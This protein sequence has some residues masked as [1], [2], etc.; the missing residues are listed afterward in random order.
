MLGAPF[1]V[2][3]PSMRNLRGGNEDN[4]SIRTACYNVCKIPLGCADIARLLGY[5]PRDTLWDFEWVTFDKSGETSDKSGVQEYQSIMLLTRGLTSGLSLKLHDGFLRYSQRY[6]GTTNILE[7][8]DH[9]PPSSMDLNFPDHSIALQASDTVRRRPEL[10]D[11]FNGKVYCAFLPVKEVHDTVCS[12]GGKTLITP[13]QTKYFNSKSRV[14]R[15]A[16]EEGYLV[17]PFVTIEGINEVEKGLSDIALKAKDLGLDPGRTRYWVKFDNLAGGEGVLPYEPLT[18]SVEEVKSWI[19]K[20]IDAEIPGSERQLFPVVI[21]IDI[22]ALPDISRI[23]GNFNIQGV[24]G[25]P[26]VTITG[27]TMQNT[28]N[29]IYLGGK[30]P[31]TP[32]EKSLAREAFDWAAPVMHAARKQGYRGYAGIDI[33]MAEGRN[34]DHLGYVIEMNGRLNCSTSLLTTAHWVEQKI[35][36]EPAARNIHAE[37]RPLPDFEDYSEAFTDVLFRGKESNYSGVIPVYLDFDSKGAVNGAKLVAV[38]P[39][40]LTLSRIET[41]HQRILDSLQP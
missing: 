21:D 4:G 29:G 40:E 15:Q 12:L 7:V 33:M 35:G 17:A 8:T 13:D 9:L 30:M 22:G 18:M 2:S 5:D 19:N 6:L 34:G 38:A 41:A 23:L 36:K 20:I 31:S 1:I 28:R 26:G 39:D 10:R 27:T 37:F 11:L 3:A 32:E 16:E 14:V 25:D 24:V